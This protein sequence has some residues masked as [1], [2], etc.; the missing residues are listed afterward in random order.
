M[1]HRDKALYCTLSTKGIACNRLVTRFAGHK[2]CSANE[3]QVKV[4]VPDAKRDKFREE[5]SWASRR[6][7]VFPLSRHA[8]QRHRRPHRKG[9]KSRR[10]L[11]VF[12]S[13]EPVPV[14]PAARL[15]TEICR[16]KDLRPLLGNHHLD[17]RHPRSRVARFSVKSSRHPRSRVAR[18]S[19]KSCLLRHVHR[20]PRPLFCSSWSK[21]KSPR[22]TLRFSISCTAAVTILKSRPRP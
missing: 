13:R 3:H 20:R 6:L 15:P 1:R 5:L 4:L 17:S 10:L 19:A 8:R 2:N 9:V 14:L 22:I 21:Q 7:L 12:D 11:R 16:K 18:F